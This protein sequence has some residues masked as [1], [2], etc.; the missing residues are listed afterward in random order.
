MRINK[1]LADFST[2]ILDTVSEVIN[3]KIGE[4]EKNLES[5]SENLTKTF[6]ETINTVVST[7][8]KGISSKVSDVSDNVNTTMSDG[9]DDEMG[10]NAE[11]LNKS[12][13]DALKAKGNIQGLVNKG[14]PQELKNIIKQAIGE[15]KKEEDKLED[16]KTN[17]IVFNLPEPKANTNEGRKADDQSFFINICN[18]I[19]NSHIPSSEIIQSRRLGREPVDQSIRPLLIKVKSESTKRKIFSQLH[20]LRISNDFPGINM[21]HDMTK[22]EKI[23]TKAKVEEAKSM[24]AELAE[25]TELD[26][27]S[28]NYVYKARGPPWNLRIDKVRFRPRT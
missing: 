24:S 7:S 10:P 3:K 27:D 2:S 19:C 12:F 26:G 17:I 28:K 21:N 9:V 8:M 6:N 15:R 1:K 13:A 22:D 16:R 20:K 23:L 11:N 4:M 14:N 5:I 18:T 25:N